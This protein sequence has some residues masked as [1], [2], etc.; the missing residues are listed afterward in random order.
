MATLDLCYVSFSKSITISRNHLEP[1]L[2][3]G[4][5]HLLAFAFRMEQNVFFWPCSSPTSCPKSKNNLSSNFVADWLLIAFAHPVTLF[6]TYSRLERIRRFCSESSTYVY[7][8]TDIFTFTFGERFAEALDVHKTLLTE[9]MSWL[10]LLRRPF[11]FHVTYY[12]LTSRVLRSRVGPIQ[13]SWK[14][15]H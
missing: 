14:L 5:P 8:V 3:H 15:A 9:R 13:F 6:W 1:I 2:P 11:L 7:K 10:E 12:C 4:I